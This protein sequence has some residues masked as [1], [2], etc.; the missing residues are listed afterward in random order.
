MWRYYLDRKDLNMEAQESM[1]A[2]KKGRKERKKKM[3]KL[4]KVRIRNKKKEQLE[5]VL[6][7]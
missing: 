4:S 1:F 2:E 5:R 6:R 7:H 3:N